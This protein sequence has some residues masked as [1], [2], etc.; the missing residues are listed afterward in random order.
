MRRLK[1]HKD[2]NFSLASSLATMMEK[3]KENVDLICEEVTN[4]ENSL[5]ALNDTYHHRC[6][7]KK[8]T[9]TR[10]R[11]ISVTESDLSPKNLPLTEVSNNHQ[12]IFRSMSSP[13]YIDLDDSVPERLSRNK[14]SNPSEISAFDLQSRLS[15]LA[16]SEFL[17]PSEVLAH[18]IKSRSYLRRIESTKSIDDSH[19]LSNCFDKRVKDDNLNRHLRLKFD[20]HPKAACRVNFDE[21]LSSNVKKGKSDFILSRI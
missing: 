17:S 7:K 18:R 11:L 14:S 21:G 5:A 16:S 13:D 9:M 15:P 10:R 19:E 1:N 3:P 4:P 8:I 2:I 12:M 20:Y 6:L